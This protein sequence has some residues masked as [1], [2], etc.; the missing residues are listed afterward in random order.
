[1]SLPKLKWN[2]SAGEGSV[3]FPK[4]FLEDS[5]VFQLDALN[6]WIFELTNKYNEIQQRFLDSNPNKKVILDVLDHETQ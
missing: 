6:D 2:S 5:F 1:M 3:K 4:E